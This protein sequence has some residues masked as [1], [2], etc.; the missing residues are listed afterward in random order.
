MMLGN[1]SHNVLQAIDDFDA[2]KSFLSTT[3]TV[4]A[5]E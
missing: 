1:L 3:A 5:A 2:L 4:D